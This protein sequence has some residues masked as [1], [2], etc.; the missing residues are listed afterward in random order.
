MSNYVCFRTGDYSVQTSTRTNSF[1]ALPTEL[2]ELQAWKFVVF[3]KF[4]S[5]YN[6]S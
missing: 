1:Q 5:S 2:G 6:S 3:R 4:F